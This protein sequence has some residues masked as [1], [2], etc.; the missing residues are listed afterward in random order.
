MDF[1]FLVI[2]DPFGNEIFHFLFI[3]KSR[4]ENIEEYGSQAISIIDTNVIEAF[5]N[6]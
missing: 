2:L 6:H 5:E 3:T 4:K 1:V